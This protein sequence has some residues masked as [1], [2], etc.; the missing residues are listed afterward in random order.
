MKKFLSITLLLC[1]FMAGQAQEYWSVSGRLVNSFTREMSET[2]RAELLYPNGKLLSGATTDK[3]GKTQAFSLRLDT[4]C[5]EY[6]LRFTHENYDTL[7]IPVKFKYHK[8]EKIINIGTYGMRKLTLAER[9]IRMGEVV[10]KATKVK[11]FYRGDT[12]V[13]NADAFQLSE[14]SMLDGLIE[15]LPGAELKDD[16]RIYVN[17]RFVDNLLL[18]GKDFFKGKNKVM[19]ENL[20]AYMVSQVKVYEEED[21]LSK[22][23]KTKVREGR[24]VMDVTLKRQYEIGWMGNAEVGGGTEE[25]YLARLFLMRFTPHSRISIYGNMNNLNDTRKPGNSGDWS[26]SDLGGGLTATKTAGIDYGVYDKYAHFTIEGSAQATHTDNDYTSRTSTQNFLTGGDTYNRSWYTSKNE[27]L[28]LN[29]S[30]NLKLNWGNSDYNS[31]SFQPYFNYNK[32]NRHSES[33]EGVF[34][35]NIQNDYALQDSLREIGASTQLIKQLLNKQN[36]LKYKT[37]HSYNTGLDIH[38]SVKIPSSTYDAIYWNAFVSYD[39]ATNET[40]DHLSLFYPSTPLDFRN[41]FYNTPDKGYSI[42]GNISYYR[43]ISGY[44]YWTIGPQYAIKHTYRSTTN[45]LYRLEQLNGMDSDE[46]GLGLLPSTTEELLTA[47]DGSNSYLTTE[48]TTTHTATIQLIWDRPLKDWK[49]GHINVNAYAVA[50]YE[51]KKMYYH[52]TLYCPKTNHAWYFTPSL[53]AIY[54]TANSKH[55]VK[56]FYNMW[57]STPSLMNMLDVT[58]DSDPLNIRKGNDRLS[59]T[60][61]HNFHL[62]YQANKWLSGTGKMLSAWLEHRI[63]YNAVSMGYVYNKETGVRTITPDNIDGNRYTQLGINFTTPIDK[64]RNLLLITNTQINLS[65]NADLIGID[66]AT[67]AQKSLVHNRYFYE[68]MRLTYKIQKHQIGIIGRVNYTRATS[69][70]S[71]FENINAFNFRYG[72]TALVKLPLDMELSTD[73][74]EHSHRGYNDASMNTNELVWNA[75]LAKNLLHGN[76]VLSLEGFDILGNL[77]NISYSLNGQGRT[78]TWVNSIPRYAMLHVVY[79]LNKQPKKK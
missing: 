51:D 28:S 53:Q 27:N 78:E 14:G 4:A 22:M 46:T 56:F 13:Y 8:R 12:L 33:L 55:I 1:H 70:R 75:R 60:T 19:L 7:L 77:S 57:V 65:E 3:D 25:R 37:G 30:H 73:L 26:P 38:S 2:I 49:R 67:E 21:E 54:N 62:E 36:N 64:A 41:R 11:F 66:G 74:T 69:S 47:L 29:T 52:G 43:K 72:L 24:Y 48:H 20:P 9:Q 6:T 61:T 40:Y 18:N 10:V 31:I 32:Y 5:T 42:G 79:R 15:Q 17:G 39:N 45:A 34:S 16:G 63:I 35:E 59:N 68:S 71:D 50:N 44:W 58:F 76:L 23:L